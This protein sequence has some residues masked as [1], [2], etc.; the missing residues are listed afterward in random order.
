[1]VELSGASVTV[2]GGV[3]GIGLALARQRNA[4][5]ARLN[6]FEPH[7]VVL[8]AAEADL[9]AQ[10]IEVAGCTRDVTKPEEVDALA[11]FVWGSHGRGDLLINNAG[12]GGPVKATIKYDVAAAR[13]LWRRSLSVRPG[14]S[15]TA[16]IWC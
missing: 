10:G 11:Y 8:E 12:V 13:A 15:V 4:R 9:Q 3:I 5:E 6:L 14:A 2:T 16:T 1:M 7:E